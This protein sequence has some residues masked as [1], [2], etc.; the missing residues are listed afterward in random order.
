VAVDGDG[1]VRVIFGVSTGAAA[2]GGDRAGSSGDVEG[3][4]GDGDV[5][6]GGGDSS[7]RGEGSGSGS[8]SGDT[9]AR[10]LES[11]IS[12]NGREVAYS[13]ADL[14]DLLPAWALTVHKAQG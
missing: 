5:G 3:G 10:A 2:S 11:L 7:S 4:G 6:N 12:G 8:G 9:I 1:G 13:R 14:R